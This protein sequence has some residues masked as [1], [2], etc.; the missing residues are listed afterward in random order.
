[1]TVSCGFELGHPGGCV[2]E[3]MGFVGDGNKFGGCQGRDNIKTMRSLRKEP[4]AHSMHETNTA[5]LPHSRRYSLET[6]YITHTHTHTHTHTLTAEAWARSIGRCTRHAQR[7]RKRP[8]R[9]R[10]PGNQED[11]IKRQ[12]FPRDQMPQKD[13]E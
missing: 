2:L 11:S 12:G 7:S 3:A 9:Q 8:V 5:K 1:M 6:L 13:D 10:F 4:K